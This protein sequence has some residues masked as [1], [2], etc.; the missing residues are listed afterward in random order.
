MKLG[1]SCAL[2]LLLGACAT[3]PTDLAFDPVASAVSG[4]VP[5]EAAAAGDAVLLVAVSAIGTAG[6]FQFQRIDAEQSDFETPPVALTFAAWGAGDKMKRPE[7]DETSL[8]VLGDEINFLIRKVPAGTYAAT[9]TGWNTFNGAYSGTASLCLSDGAKTFTVAPGSLSVVDSRDAFPPGSMARLGGNHSDADVLA[10]FALTRQNYPDL[11]GEP[12][13]LSPEGEA[14]WT[15]K[16]GFF[17]NPCEIALP[18]TLS[19]SRIRLDTAQTEP[20]EAE[21]AAIAAALANAAA[22]A[23]QAQPE[24]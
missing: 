5:G 2:V 14:R 24:N 19:V 15:E 13:L 1:W 6:F 17:V 4:A 3:A 10:Q 18:G 12:V 23:T 11:K 22:P 9:Y 7:G 21:K 8:W 16:T 20:D